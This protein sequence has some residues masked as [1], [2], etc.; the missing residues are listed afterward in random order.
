MTEIIDRFEGKYRF[1]SNFYPCKIIYQGIEYPSV[2]HAYQASKT[3]DISSRQKIAEKKTPTEAK[4]M[5]R[6][7]KLRNDWEQIKLDLMEELIK[8]KFSNH[9]D[10]RDKLLRTNQS[11]LIEGNTWGDNFWGIY[12][13][14]GENHL[15]KILMKVRNEIKKETQS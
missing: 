13:G 15:G 11:E 12:K 9:Q 3:L 14:R 2:E 5:G 4:R 8:Q 1:L 7:V 6:K 10:L